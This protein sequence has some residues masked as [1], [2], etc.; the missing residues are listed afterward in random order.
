MRLRAWYRRVG[1]SRM[2]IVGLAAMAG[3]TVFGR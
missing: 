2:S 1:V 3:Y